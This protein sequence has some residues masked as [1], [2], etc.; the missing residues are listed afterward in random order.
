MT[1]TTLKRRATSKLVQKIEARVRADEVA[2]EAIAE[3]RRRR[4]AKSERL[5][6]ARIQAEAQERQL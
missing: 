2:R 1:D 5:R 3:E 6:A 4:D